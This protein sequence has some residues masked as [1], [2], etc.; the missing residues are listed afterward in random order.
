M[1]IPVIDKSKEVRPSVIDIADSVN[2]LL[3]T[4]LLKNVYRLE[5]G[6][7]L[8]GSIAANGYVDIQVTFDVALPSSAAL[9][10]IFFSIVNA[11]CDKPLLAMI[12]ARSRSGFTAR[13]FNLDATAHSPRL[14]WLS[15][16]NYN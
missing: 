10:W 1:A 9:P 13:V 8:T 7:V 3:D 11:N 2:T 6:N 14:V 12:Q 4:A 15:I 16:S 5:T